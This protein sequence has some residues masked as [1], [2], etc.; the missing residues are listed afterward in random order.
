MLDLQELAS[1][2]LQTERDNQAGMRQEVEEL[3]NEYRTLAHDHKVR[4]PTSKRW[5]ASDR[6]IPR[7]SR[8][9][10]TKCQRNL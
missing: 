4:L 8:S 9:I 6:S 5:H 10:P 2:Q 7:N 1:K 3:D